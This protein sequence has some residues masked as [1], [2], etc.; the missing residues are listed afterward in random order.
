MLIAKDSQHVEWSG[1]MRLNV[2]IDLSGTLH[3]G[4]VACPGAVDA[5]RRL[6]KAK[7][8]SGSSF[9]FRFCSNTTKESTEDLQDRL[10]RAGFDAADVAAR[11]IT[12]SLEACTRLCIDKRWRPMLLL[13]PSA[14]QSFKRAYAEEGLEQ[15]AFYVES[16]KQPDNMSEQERSKLR[17]CDTVVVGLAPD[18]FNA[19][20]L[21][22]AFRIL[23]GEYGGGEK[24]LVATHRGRFASVF[25][26]IPC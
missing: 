14:Q 3:I 17:Q 6:S 8:A 26:H 23:S 4:D 1:V 13:T 16:D 25:L 7:P 18:L 10:R 19:R 2:L 5:V 21:D 12:T 24:R 9:A 20:W 11:R 22:E 15:H